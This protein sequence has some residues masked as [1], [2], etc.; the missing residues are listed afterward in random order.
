[1]GVSTASATFF[2]QIGGTLGV[3]LFLSI[4]FAQLTPSITTQL[5]DAARS[6]ESTGGRGRCEQPET[7]EAEIA[8]GLMSGDPSAASAAMNDT[9][10]IEQLNPTLAAPFKDG[11][12]IAFEAVYRR[13][14]SSPSCRWC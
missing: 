1:M 8:R 9:S 5:Q 2:R 11:F 6:P 13:S 14:W 4:L 7:V 12:A 3:A 10:F